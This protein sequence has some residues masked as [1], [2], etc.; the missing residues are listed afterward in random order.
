MF[1]KSGPYF[2]TEVLRLGFPSGL[3]SQ[4]HFLSMTQEVARESPKGQLKYWVFT[5]CNPTMTPVEFIEKLTERNDF[6]YVSFQG[7]RAPTTNMYHY[8][9][10]LEL[11]R[12]VRFTALKKIHDAI[13]WQGR[14]GTQQQ[15][16]AY[17]Q[18]ADTR[19]DG[20]YESGV[21]SAND[22]GQRTDIQIAVA[23]VREHGLRALVDQHPEMFIRGHRGFTAYAAYYPPKKPVPEVILIQGKAGKGK[24]RVFWDTYLES[25]DWWA[26]PIGDSL[27][28]DCYDQQKYVL[29]DDFDG[30]SAKFPLTSLLRLLD[31]YPLQVPVKGSHAW[32]V[33]EKIYIT[34]NIHPNDWYD[35]T[36][37]REHY[38]A[39]VRRISR[40]IL[41]Q[42]DGLEPQVLT[43]PRS[44]V[45]AQEEASANASMWQHYFF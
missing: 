41:P 14:R 36:N 9:G 17:T 12:K 25:G 18:K 16:I 31:R 32:W 6:R 21:P 24:S 20:P 19:A 23:L 3:Q 35:Y 1:G 4:S 38:N 27:W 10:Y 11:T 42:G 29:I 22:Q 43:A 15:A 44:G 39:L 26:T 34:T 13:S 33:P 7:E 8:Q 28:F 37:R 30:R 40:V 5:W 45:S 2:L